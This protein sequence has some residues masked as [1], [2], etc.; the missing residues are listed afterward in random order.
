MEEKCIDEMTAVQDAFLSGT[1]ADMK[2]CLR[3]VQQCLVPTIA[4][5]EDKAAA[6]CRLAPP[7]RTQEDASQAASQGANARVLVETSLAYRFDG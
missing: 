6:A 5:S 4:R 2:R 3:D 1:Y 7:R